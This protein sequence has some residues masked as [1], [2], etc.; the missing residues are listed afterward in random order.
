MTR[1]SM[2]GRHL[3]IRSLP[4]HGAPSYAASWCSLGTSKEVPN[5]VYRA[6]RLE[7][8]TIASRPDSGL[9]RNVYATRDRARKL[10]QFALEG[11]RRADMLRAHAARQDGRERE[12]QAE[13]T[14]APASS[15]LRVPHRFHAQHRETVEQ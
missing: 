14:K 6:C 11:Q 5:V 10:R 1:T 12:A 13:E 7:C 15:M 4:A 8:G 3:I 9:Y 2:S